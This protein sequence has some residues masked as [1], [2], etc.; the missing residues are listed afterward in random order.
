MPPD[1]SH[2]LTL[3]GTV[4]GIDEA[5]RG[6]LCGPVVAACVYVP[7]T[8][9]AHGF[10]THVNDSKKLKPKQRDILFDDICAACS[11]GIGQASVQEIDTLNIL[12]ATLLA[13]RRAYNAMGVDCTTAL[14][15]GNRA[16]ALPCRAQ[17]LVSGDAKSLSIAAASILAKVT[18]DRLMLELDAAY[19]AYG[20]A[21]NAGYGT[22]AHLQALAAHGPTSH[23]RT[24]FAPLKKAV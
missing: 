18:R 5:G 7:E 8:A 13:M 24:S 11:F 9:R 21:Q 17:T 20:W 10:W 15:D 14:I 23:H 3:S 2:E 1:F 12:Q 16:P 6:P 22:E 19:P 4:C